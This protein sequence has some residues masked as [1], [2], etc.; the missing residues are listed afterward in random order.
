MK[1]FS[2]KSL[3][4]IFPFCLT[5]LKQVNNKT[6]QTNMNK[7]K[8]EIPPKATTSP[9][10]TTGTT[11]TVEPKVDNNL[12]VSLQRTPCFG[13]CPVFKIQMFNDGKVVYEGKAHCKR[14]GTYKAVASAEL[15]KVIQQKASD[16][17]YLSFE[18]RY[19]KGESM[20]TDIP[21]TISYIKVGS[22]SKMVANNY[23]APKELV[24]FERWL[25]QQ[26]ETLKW[27]TKE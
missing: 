11:K 21:T 14:M 24:E 13:Q 6:T 16:I 22:D 23:D 25:E 2:M 12:L 26:F 8:E 3:I 9:T 10:T 15:I 7:A 4:F 27:E 5:L 17:K 18:E 1:F 19:P 20:I